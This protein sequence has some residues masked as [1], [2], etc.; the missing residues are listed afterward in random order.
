MTLT[1]S[2]LSDL[3]AAIKAGEMTDTIRTSLEWVLQQL[4]E[5]EATAFIG[6][7][8]HERTDTRVT[9][10]NGHR[11]RLLSTTAGD[12]ELA[13]P[14]LREGSFYPSLLERRRRIDRAL[15]AVVMEA[16][17][18]GVSTRKVDDLVKALG[19]ASGISKSE[20][21]RICTQLDTD[22]EA[23]RNRPLDHVEFRYVFADATYVKGRVNGRVVSRAVVV[24]TGV[25][26]NGDREVLGVE[27]GDSEDG[28]F[29][30]SFLRSL[31][32]RGLTGVQL[33]IS[34]HHLGL[35]AA[36]AGVF[37]GSAW[38]RCRVHFMRNVLARVPT[39]S[40]EMVAAAVRTVF[41]Q[42]DPQHVRRQLAEVAD[43]LR[44]QFP[45]V[46]AMLTDAAEDILAFT[47]FPHAHWRKVWSTNPLERLN[48]EIKRRTNVVGIFPNDAS[49]LRLITAVIVE[50]HD[51]WQ[52]TERRY[53]SEDSMAKLYATDNTVPDTLPEAPLAV[54]A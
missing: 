21:S 37:I 18:H 29:W 40:A 32:V 2:D 38:Q 17:V 22:L 3:L 16:W 1:D 9:Q 13:I 7:A 27:V 52:V 34:D 44:S 5:A 15:Y 39:A 43:M 53:L 19:V 20:V 41:A 45:D 25:T 30:T 26:A 6:A 50:T 47:A 54:T 28:A 42:P 33:V 14:K 12:V 46:A 31:R 24:A 4:I 36:I 23:F 8:R 10:R 48:G 51:E 49:V 11:P 35:K